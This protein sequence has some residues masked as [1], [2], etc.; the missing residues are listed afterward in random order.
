[1]TG[2]P[3][4]TSASRPA[5]ELSLFDST[6]LVVGIIIGVGIYQMAP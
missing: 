5:R 2:N 4:A 3:N 1:M 6:S